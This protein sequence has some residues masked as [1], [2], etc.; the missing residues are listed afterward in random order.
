MVISQ[1]VRMKQAI[2]FFFGLIFVE[3][4]SINVKAMKKIYTTLLICF[5][6]IT[7][8]A[9]NEFYIK[10]NGTNNEVT[11]KGNDGTNPT[12]YVKGEIVNDGGEFINDN[13]TIELTGDWT[14][15]PATGKYESTGKT[16]FSGTSDQTISG[17]MNGTTDGTL[18]ATTSG[19]NQFYKVD[20]NSTS[21]V[22]LDDDVNVHSDGTATF[23]ASATTVVKDN[24]GSEKFYIRNSAVASLSGYGATGAT[25]K[26]F[27]SALWRESVNGNSYD[28]PVGYSSG[29]TAATGEGVQMATI[30]VTGATGSGALES[31]F[32]F[33]GAS[34][35]PI[36]ICPGAP[37]PEAQDVD[38][39]LN[40]GHWMISNGAGNISE[41]SITLDPADY[42]ALTGPGDYTIVQNGGPTGMDPCDGSI[43]GLSITHAGLTSFS[44]FEVGASTD[45]APLPVELLTLTA[46]PIEN[47]FIRVDWT[48]ASE[49][50]NEG[51]EVQRGIDGIEFSAESWVDGNGTTTAMHDYNYDDYEVEY[52]QLYYYRLKQIDHNGDYEYSHVVSAMITKDGEGFITT[53]YPNP[54]VNSSTLGVQATKEQAGTIKVYNVWG[55]LITNQAVEIRAGTNEY[56]INTEHLASGNYYINLELQNQV[57][58]HKLIV[59]K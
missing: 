33:G 3:F 9:Q 45:G 31:K 10:G 23:T 18:S 8:G 34:A 25:S 58:N 5:L 32:N 42:T 56:V 57:V 17:T 47:E 53:L 49:L 55:Q 26:F 50:N 28:L 11:V 51:F 43:T 27:T 59:N 6:M 44:K 19:I 39:I 21:T 2:L 16:T 41:Y 22:T 40:N 38:A 12:L 7:V 1:I 29:A 4:M 15:T 48:T 20:F 52:N 35:T 54:T 36:S 14:N 46:Y 24:G 30:A 13:G 37:T